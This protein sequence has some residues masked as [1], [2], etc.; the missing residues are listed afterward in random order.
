MPETRVIVAGTT[1]DY[2]EYIYCKYPGRAMFITA[3]REREKAAET[4]PA[5]C[6]EIVCDLED[7]DHVIKLLKEHL[8]KWNITPAGIACYDCESL[9]LGSR[10]A[11]KLGLPFPCPDAISI[12]RNKYFSKQIWHKAGI[13]CPEAA[14]VSKLTDIYQFMDHVKA[15]VIIKPLT[16]S[17]SELVFKC[18]NYSRCDQAFHMIKTGLAGHSNLR[19]YKP[20]KDEQNIDSRDFFAVETFI[21]GNEYSCD[22][23]INGP[24]FEIIR[25]AGK[26]PDVNQPAGT[27]LAYIVPGKLFDEIEYTGFIDQIKKAAEVLGLTRAICMA[28]FIVCNG[29]AY[30]LEITPRPGGDCLPRLILKTRGL[31]II[32]LALDFAENRSNILPDCSYFEQSC[33]EQLAGLRLFSN[34]AGIIKNINTDLIIQDSRVLECQIRC[35]PGHRVVLPPDDYDSRVLGHLIF[36]PSVLH[37]LET[38]CLD[39]SSKLKIEMESD[40]EFSKILN[41]GKSRKSS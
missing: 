38:Q 26:I 34:Q 6:D 3:C 11:Q 12:S 31:D 41:Y 27:T 25:I 36:K 20:G 23:I 14:V 8:S 29:K 30:L 15:P 39:L 37:D 9:E 28:D 32:G 19:M 17:G 40:N 24:Y 5:P 1:P 33:S 7:L 22:F 4:G 13:P 35:K 21:Q 2:I 18:E 16:G 10:A